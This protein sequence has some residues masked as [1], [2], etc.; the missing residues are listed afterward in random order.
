MVDLVRPISEGGEVTLNSADALQQPNINLNYFNDELDIIA[1]REGI[2]Y[3]YDVLVKGE[4]F[5]DIIEE[6]YPWEMPLDDDEMMKKTQGVVD[7]I[8]KVHGIKNLRVADASVMP[9]IPDCRI[10]N[11]VY[12][13]AEKGADLI[14]A[15]HKDL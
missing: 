7:P 4:G 9:V 11:S 8:L 3:S 10:Q 14:K 6:E 15:D 2:R 1:I 5:K 12:M 13:V